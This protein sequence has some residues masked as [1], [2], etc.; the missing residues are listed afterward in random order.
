MLAL[1]G[2]TF[3]QQDGFYLALKY[4]KQ[5]QTIFLTMDV[6][7][8]EIPVLYQ[9]LLSHYFL[10]EYAQAME[11]GGRCLEIAKDLGWR[12]LEAHLLHRQGIHYQ[13]MN[14]HL[15]AAMYYKKSWLI[16]KEI[17]ADE[18]QIQN[19]RN[20]GD[21]YLAKY[22]IE[23]ALQIYQE[24][25]KIAR[26]LS[27]RIEE[28]RCLESLAKAFFYMGDLKRAYGSSQ[29]SLQIKQNVGISFMQKT[30]NFIEREYFLQDYCDDFF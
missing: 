7:K 6:Q 13:V 25:L 5:A 26:Q 18:L 14:N 27:S 20:L 24:S 12:F 28:A 2:D 22:F 11:I 17:G 15:E 30:V 4:Y 16:A 19:M 23:D 29:L 8:S 3:Y 9:M 10:G 21:L 1:I